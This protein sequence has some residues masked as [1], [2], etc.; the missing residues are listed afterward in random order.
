VSD[1][2]DSSGLAAPALSAAV[3]AAELESRPILVV[4]FWTDQQERRG[5]LTAEF[6]S[7]RIFEAAFRAAHEIP[8]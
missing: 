3:L 2:L 4:A 5:A 6:H 8:R 7:L 1:V